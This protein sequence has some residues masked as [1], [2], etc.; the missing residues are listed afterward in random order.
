MGASDGAGGFTI[1]ITRYLQESLFTSS[2]VLLTI[3]WD[4][5]T[6]SLN[7]GW[8]MTSGLEV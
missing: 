5:R 8:I 1:T 6:P 2:S 4:V 3:A 7:L